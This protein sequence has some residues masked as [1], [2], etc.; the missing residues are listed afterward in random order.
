MKPSQDSDD[1]GRSTPE[2]LK[3]I[4]VNIESDSEEQPKKI[5]RKHRT[6]SETLK[7]LDDDIVADL[8]VK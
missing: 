4:N 2:H 8:D 5:Q 6:F 1:S 7:L 3:D